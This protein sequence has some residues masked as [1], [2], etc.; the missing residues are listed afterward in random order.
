MLTQDVPNGGQFS[1]E[2]VLIPF[3]E[4]SQ[5]IQQVIQGWCI[6]GWWAFA[7]MECN[8]ASIGAESR[9]AATAGRI[10]HQ[11][12]AAGFTFGV[13]WKVTFF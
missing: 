3:S 1:A 5:C 11:R 6:L 12:F 8:S 2:G 4:F 7:P 10:N 13:G 9:H